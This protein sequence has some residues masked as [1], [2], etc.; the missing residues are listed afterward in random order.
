MAVQS[1]SWTLAR[2]AGAEPGVP[3]QILH[4]REAFTDQVREAPA[5]DST[6]RPPVG[7]SNTSPSSPI[8]SGGIWRAT[9][10]TEAIH[11]RP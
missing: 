1:P 10:S 5:K 7:P 6:R 9:Q 2:L 8:P 3:I 11:A 4:G